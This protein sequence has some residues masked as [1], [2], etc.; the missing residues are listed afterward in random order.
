MESK[1]FLKA[2]LCFYGVAAF[3]S[4]DYSAEYSLVIRSRITKIRYS[5]GFANGAIVT[6][7][8]V[9]SLPKL[10]NTITKAW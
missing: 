7:R 10:G 4:Y 2:L 5:R 1:A 6:K 9:T 8:L 3:I